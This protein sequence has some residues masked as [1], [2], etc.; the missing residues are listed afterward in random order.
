M[1]SSIKLP[2]LKKGEYILWTIKM[3]Q[4][5]DHT[6]YALW[7]EILNGNSAVQMTKDEAGNEVE[8]PP[9]TAH[10]IL[11][12]TREIK[13]KSTLLMAIPNEHLARFHGIKDTKTLWAAIKTRFGGNAESKKIQKNVL[14]Q[15]FEIFSVSNLEGLDKGYDRFQRLLSLLEIHG[16]ESTSSTNEL[17]V[18][19]SVSTAI[20][21][22]SQAQGSSSYANE[23]MFSF[24]ANQSSSP[25]LD[26]KDLEQIDQDDLEEMDVKWDCKTARNSGNRSRDAGNAWYRGRDN[27]KRPPK[28]E[29]EK[30]LVVQ[31]GI[32]KEVTETVFDNHSSD[33]ENS[34]TNDRFKKG[35]GYHA[36]PFPL[37]GNYMPPK[38][39]LSFAG[40]D[41]S[42]YKFKISETI[43]SLTKDEKDAL[44][45]S[46]SCIE[47]PKEDSISHLIK[48]CTF[49]EDRMAKKSVLPNNVGKG[50]GH[51][52]SRPVWNNVQRINHQ[53]K[54]APIAVFTRSG[55]I[56]VSAAK[57]KVAASTSVAKPVDTDGPK[58]SVHF[59]KSR[60]TFHKSHSPIRRSF[61]NAT[62]HSRRNSTKRVNTAGSKAVSVVKGNRVT[63]V[64]TLASCVWRPRGHPQQALK[65]KGI[66]D[67]GCSRHLT[68]NKAYLADYQE[69]NDGGFVAFG[70]SRGKITDKASIDES[71]LWHMRLGHVNFKTM[72]TLAKGNLIR[73]LP[74]KFFENDLTCV[75]CQKGK[76]HK[77]TCKAKLVSSIDQPLQMLHMDLF[78]P[79]SI[80]SINHKKYCLV[81]T[82]D[83][84]RFSWV[85]FLATKDVTSKVLKPFITDIENQLNKKVKVI[86]YD[87]GTEF[88]NRDL[89]E[90][91]RMKR[92]KREYSNARTP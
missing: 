54:F 11:A 62:T 78:G 21:H 70:S 14:K 50:T 66:I 15:Q 39:N 89:G 72:N 17:N 6:D 60:S 27:G 48:D 10:R 92:I 31:D 34:L 47:K 28:E 16:A 5:L 84:S 20:G 88:K 86:R 68:R 52:K 91:C 18:T 63:D 12:R 23:L 29:D 7:E 13:A 22:S 61:Y 82:D 53:N 43:T 3:E 87:N 44:E 71:N 36:V 75:A 33:E 25:R 64:K 19:Y 45:T 90:F 57:P 65:N 67:S 74:S 58:Q 42:I 24:F 2:I 8:I 32:E 9:I 73:G 30:A 37:T 81:V 79:T 80:M 56:P 35:E 51:K 77:V 46:A 59:S 49:H 83:F 41:D 26:N 4:Y 1:V 69:I 85:F 38:S 40:L 76:Q 55:R